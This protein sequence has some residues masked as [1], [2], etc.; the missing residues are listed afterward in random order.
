MTE[1]W[2][3]VWTWKLSRFMAIGEINIAGQKSKIVELSMEWYVGKEFFGKSTLVFR[4]Y[5]FLWHKLPPR[6]SHGMRNAEQKRWYS[7]WLWEKPAPVSP[8]TTSHV[9]RNAL[10]LCLRTRTDNIYSP[11]KPGLSWGTLAAMLKSWLSIPLESLMGSGWE[12]KG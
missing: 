1:I 3:W 6:P 11:V 10:S 9:G 4:V 2:T 5:Q 8:D 12:R 7:Q